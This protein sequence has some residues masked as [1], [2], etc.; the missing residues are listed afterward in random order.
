MQPLERQRGAR[1]ARCPTL[2]AGSPRP[3]A[4]ARTRRSAA[5]PRRRRRSRCARVLDLD[6]LPVRAPAP[7]RPAPGRGRARRAAARR[8]RTAR[9]PVEHRGHRRAP[10]R[11]P[12]TP[13]AQ[14]LGGGAEALDAGP[15]DRAGHRAQRRGAAGQ[16]GW[17]GERLELE[18]EASSQPR[19]PAAARSARPRAPPGTLSAPALE[20]Q[21]HARARRPVEVTGGVE[22]GERERAVG[23]RSAAACS[24]PAAGRS[25]CSVAVPST[26]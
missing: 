22:E 10:R 26:S 2:G 15:L 13:A 24:C 25:S 21:R 8:P 5:G 7:P 9:G 14:C 20:Q 11:A 23:H 17:L 1:L 19:V 18:L 6:E 4:T 3:G 12:S 16:L